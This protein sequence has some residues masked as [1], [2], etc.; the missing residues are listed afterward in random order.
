MKPILLFLF[1]SLGLL[2][3]AEKPPVVSAPKPNVL[4]IAIDD[5]NDWLGCYETLT[6][7][8]TPNIDRFAKHGLWRE[9]TR[10]LLIFAGPGIAENQRRNQPVGLIDMYP[11]L[12][13]LCCLPEKPSALAFNAS[14]TGVSLPDLYSA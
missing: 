13:D 12:L 3:A 5:L 6:G 4:F 7:T 9:A 8:E 14:F 2:R 10:V 11:T 1:A